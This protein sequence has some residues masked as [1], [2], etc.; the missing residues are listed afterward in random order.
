[1]TQKKNNAGINGKQPAVKKLGGVTGKG[2][3]PG[4]SGNPNGRPRTRGLLVQLKAELGEVTKGRSA[5]EL[6]AQK[7]VNLAKRG[8]LAA[9]RECFDR[10]EGK[11]R[12][13]FDL[14]DERRQLQGRTDE[15]K[16]HLAVH[17]LW[18]EEREQ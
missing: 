2:F 1:M 9:I 11:P 12:Q 4:Q 8:N 14:N 18:P 16:L 15:E 5:E 10:L 17:G 13:A 6:I 7:L 3:M